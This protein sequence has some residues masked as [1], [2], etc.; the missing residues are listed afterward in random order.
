VVE[1]SNM[2]VA[3]S[4]DQLKLCCLMFDADLGY[5]NINCVVSLCLSV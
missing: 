3:V 5:A 2:T 4:T 1:L